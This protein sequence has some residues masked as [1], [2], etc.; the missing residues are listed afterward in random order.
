[1]ST[2]KQRFAAWLKTTPYFSLRREVPEKYLR[3]LQTVVEARGTHV[4]MWPSP[5]TVSEAYRLGLPV[6]A[7]MVYTPQEA[8]DFLAE[9][10]P[11]SLLLQYADIGLTPMQAMQAAD[12]GHHPSFVQAAFNF[13]GSEKMMWLRLMG[14]TAPVMEKM[15]KRAATFGSATRYVKPCLDMGIPWSTFCEYGT[16]VPLTIAVPALQTGKTPAEI[17]EWMDTFAD[18]FYD[19]MW[20]VDVNV[21]SMRWHPKAINS[22]TRAVQQFIREMYE[23]AHPG[24]PD[25]YL[26]ALIEH[27]DGVL[28]P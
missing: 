2:R 12:E 4:T 18:G 8:A 16:V 20:V 26:I 25:E 3:A 17:Q 28:A 5:P 21:E 24:L 1:M 23:W 15:S 6:E 19:K 11:L 13:G 27:P 22:P 14:I 9:G 10:Y 7:V